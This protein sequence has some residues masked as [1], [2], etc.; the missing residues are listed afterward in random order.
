MTAAESTIPATWRERYIDADDVRLH[1]V[2][3]G[4]IGAPL[5]VLQHGFPEFW[6]AWRR[7]IDPLAGA[8]FHVVALDQRGYN[9]SAK[10]SEVAAYRV[11]HLR[12][13]IVA[14]IDALGAKTASLV[15]HDW[16]GHVAWSVAEH[17][18]DRLDRLVAINAGH[19]AAMMHNLV[20]N[21]R[22]TLKSWYAAAFQIPRIPER[23][24]SGK[25]YER[26]LNAMDWKGD[27]G[28][29]TSDDAA[30]YVT[31]WSRDRALTSMINWY[32]AF[33][34]RF[35]SVSRPQITVPTL[36][37]W[38]ERDQFLDANVARESITFCTRGE[39]RFLDGTHWVHHEHP[40][41]V[42]DHVVSFL[43]GRASPRGSR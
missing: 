38:G 9:L 35:P 8:G 10:P 6:F 13:D 17:S 28:P 29:M 11:E 2:E 43:A 21:P 7:L 41:L 36:L 34:R 19:P 32:R 40:M 18:P 22:Q 23:L 14:V 42:A 1:A 25:N 31:A 20:T 3:A 24:L 16:G 4:D 33:G 5:V 39:L 12:H 26:L 30:S 27:R 37:L 15:G